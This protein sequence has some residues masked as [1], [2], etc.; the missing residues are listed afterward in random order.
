MVSVIAIINLNKMHL[1]VLRWKFPSHFFSNYE[2]K[3]FLERCFYENK[4]KQE[5][6]SDTSKFNLSSE[7]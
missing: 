6:Q 2:E 5:K 3:F 1:I 7:L 4:L